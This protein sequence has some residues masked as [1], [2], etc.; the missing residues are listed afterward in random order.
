MKKIV[1]F[2]LLFYAVSIACFG[3]DNTSTEKSYPLEDAEIER[4]LEY[5]DIEGEKYAAVVVTLKSSSPDYIFTS[6]YK[7]RVTVR[8]IE[9]KRIWGKTFNAYLYVFSD[10]EVHVGKPKFTQLLIYKSEMFDGYVGIVKEKE[11]IY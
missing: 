8:S 3:Q 7:V 4:R 5:I 10:G 6:K 2:L 9:G 1:S 11:G